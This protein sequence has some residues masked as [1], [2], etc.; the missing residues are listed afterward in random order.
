MPSS[1]PWPTIEGHM[2]KVLP[3]KSGP[4]H[5]PTRTSSQFCPGL[6]LGLVP[7]TGQLG[8]RW[9]LSTSLT[10]QDLKGTEAVLWKC[11]L[12]GPRSSV[13]ME[14]LKEQR[15]H[16]RDVELADVAERIDDLRDLRG[17]QYGR[18]GVS[19][20]SRSRLTNGRGS[21]LMAPSRPVCRCRGDS[22]RGRTKD[23]RVP[24]RTP[25]TVQPRRRDRR[26][27]RRELAAGTCKPVPWLV[28]RADPEN[29]DTHEKPNQM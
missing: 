24:K 15:R 22:S 23:I 9:V 13:R 28:A 26:S 10:A 12:T 4:G 7:S 29:R 2:N 5:R 3:N 16:C 18:I 27:P 6:N 14:R 20:S 1:C 17:Q 21:G 8:P 19:A 25:L 11:L